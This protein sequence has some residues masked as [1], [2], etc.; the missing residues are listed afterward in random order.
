MKRTLLKPAAV[1]VALLLA[2][3]ACGTDSGD[4]SSDSGSGGFTAPDVP[5]KKSLGGRIDLDTSLQQIQGAL[6]K[7][8]D[9][10]IKEFKWEDEAKQW[11]P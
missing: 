2:L 1:A 8:A 4:S 11:K 9:E 10:A 6:D 3:A 5:M 7:A